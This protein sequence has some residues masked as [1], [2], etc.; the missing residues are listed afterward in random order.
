MVLFQFSFC[1]QPVGMLAYALRQRV[2]RFVPVLGIDAFQWVAAEVSTGSTFQIARVLGDLRGGSDAAD[3]EAPPLRFMKRLVVL[4]CMAVADVVY[5][6]VAQ[7]MDALMWSVVRHSVLPRALDR[8]SHTSAHVS[9][10]TATRCSS[11]ITGMGTLATAAKLS[12]TIEPT[13][14]GGKGIDPQKIL[15]A[16]T[17]GG[18]RRDKRSEVAL[19]RA[20]IL[21]A[22]YQTAK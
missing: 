11:S 1:E 10:R 5:E 18:R 2:R 19:K 9:T 16:Q 20:G 14:M 4:A 13:Y 21:S 6:A 22:G 8:A 12:V 15:D 7:L 3:L 17:W